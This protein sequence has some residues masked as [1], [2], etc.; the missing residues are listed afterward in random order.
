MKKSTE[1]IS[2]NWKKIQSEL[3]ALVG[4]AAK[5]NNQ[6]QFH[7]AS[8][9]QSELIE[10]EAGPQA[11]SASTVES[12][13][14]R[15]RHKLECLLKDQEQLQIQQSNYEEAIRKQNEEFIQLATELEQQTAQNKQLEEKIQEQEIQNKNL[16][17]QTQNNNSHLK[18]QL[19]ISETKLS[20]L[21]SKLRKLERENRE[22]KQTIEGYQ[23]KMQKWT[24]TLEND[25]QTE[26]QLDAIVNAALKDEPDEGS[27]TRDVPRKQV[28]EMLDRHD[29]QLKKAKADYQFQLNS[30]EQ[31]FQE[32]QSQQSELK[33]ELQQ[34]QH[35][36]EELATLLNMHSKHITTLKQALEQSSQGNTAGAADALTII[37]ENDHWTSTRDALLKQGQLP[38]QFQE[39]TS[40]TDSLPAELV[41]I[42]LTSP[43]PDRSPPSLSSNGSNEDYDSNNNNGN[44]NGVESGQNSPQLQKEM[45]TQSLPTVPKLP[46]PDML[47]SL[48]ILS[49]SE[50]YDL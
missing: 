6:S 26:K 9:L 37:L 27:A 50:S 14:L 13:I 19:N 34:R 5:V 47:Y 12:T 24:A 48:P 22:L 11:I 2:S 31:M 17:R 33:Q 29:Q 21:N 4:S 46:E 36:I 45:F 30:A 40:T 18:T 39:K 49:R 15:I 7:Q 44:D 10:A 35:T 43:R 38:E 1:E 42:S 41:K 23:A 25:L 3:L 32:S 8:D 20:T 16:N 28:N